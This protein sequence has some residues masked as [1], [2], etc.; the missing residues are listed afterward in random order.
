MLW[1]TDFQVFL[2]NFNNKKQIKHIQKMRKQLTF[3]ATFFQSHPGFSCLHRV[4]PLQV[5]RQQAFQDVV[6]G[7]G[8]VTA[9]LMA[10]RQASQRVLTTHRRARPGWP[11]NRRVRC[12]GR[13]RGL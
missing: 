2:L 12:R 10:G 3:F 1:K 11:G 8:G 9:S 13:L 5:E 4:G 6:V 7:S